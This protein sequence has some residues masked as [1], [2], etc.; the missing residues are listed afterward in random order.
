MIAAFPSPRPWGPGLRAAALALVGLCALAQAPWAQDAGTRAHDTNQPI[1][2]NADS[3]E[4][5]QE[6]RIATFRGNVVAIQGDIRL[7]AD[8]LRVH[9]REGEDR[10]DEVGATIARIDA[11]GNVFMSSPSETAQGEDG[12]YDVENRVITLLGSVVPTR[13]E[14]VIRGH[15]LV[16]DLAT[17]RSRV[18]GGAT[19]GERVR[20][21]FVPAKKEAAE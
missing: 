15:R 13:G 4:V 21:L 16:L 9:Y 3:L 11:F 7:R 17:G 1:E 5:D 20:A 10:G 8:T 19:G 18:D 2:I 14:N 12:V 6:K